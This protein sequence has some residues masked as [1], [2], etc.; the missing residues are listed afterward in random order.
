MSPKGPHALRLLLQGLEDPTRQLHPAGLGIND[1]APFKLLTDSAALIPAEGAPVVVMCPGCAEFDVAPE[2]DER[3]LRG[4]CPA[5]GYVRIHSEYLRRWQ[6]DIP[7][8]LAKLRRAFG[9]ESRQ[10]SQALID[11]RLWKV[12]DVG[13]KTQRRHVFLA[14]RLTEPQAQLQLRTAV[15]AIAERG[16]SVIVGALSRRQVDLDDVSLIYLPLDFLFHWRSGGLHLDQGLWHWCLK[17][18]HLRNHSGSQ[19]FSEDF[20]TAILEGEEYTFTDKQSQ[21]WELLVSADGAKQQRDWIMAQIDSPQPNPRALFRHNPRQLTAFDQ[22][23]EHDD[24]GF[25]WMKVA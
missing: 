14:R 15:R 4:L 5:C 21:F 25:H 8:L 17:P 11:D 9:I 23:V 13:Q 6:V 24:E 20:R 16:R 19:V 18:L 7:W 1:L 22:L 2:Q 12:G 3:G 10:I